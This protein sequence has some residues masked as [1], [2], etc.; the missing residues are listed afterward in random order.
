MHFRELNR[1]VTLLKM[2]ESVDTRSGEVV[3]TVATAHNVWA[4]ITDVRTMEGANVSA[5]DTTARCVFT[6]R[7]REDVD[8]TWRVLDQKGRTWLIEGEPEEVGKRQ[9]LKLYCAQVT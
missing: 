7:Y 8:H 3:S 9:Y 1:P 4:S 6:V 2:A 5:Q